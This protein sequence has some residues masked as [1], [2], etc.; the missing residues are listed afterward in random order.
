MLDYFSAAAKKLEFAT[1]SFIHQHIPEAVLV[2][3]FASEL[4]YQ[5]PDD[6]ASVK[7]F[8]DFFTEMDKKL[9]DLGFSGYGISSCSLEEV[10][11]YISVVF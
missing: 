8:Y 2:E 1:T 4:T 9:K 3:S 5:L 6:P 11:F 7:K 10:Q